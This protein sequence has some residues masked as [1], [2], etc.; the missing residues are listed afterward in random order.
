M[1]ILRTYRETWIG[2]GM[3][4]FTSVYF[5]NTLEI[6]D[7]GLTGS[8]Y[9]ATIPQWLSYVMW[10]LSAALILTDVSKQRKAAASGER[11]KD[12]AQKSSV[13]WLTFILTIAVLVGYVLL[14]SVLGFCP[15]TALFLFGEI[16]I[17]CEPGKHKWALFAIIAIVVSIA[18][19]CAFRLGLNLM[20][21][22]GI[23]PF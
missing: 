13:N 7:L 21:P 19:Y 4:I 11:E 6:K 9:A 8:V 14:I 20:L 17:L 18:A 5:Y 15:A 22:R 23:M 10:L 2:V 12:T 16:S 3:A 1:S